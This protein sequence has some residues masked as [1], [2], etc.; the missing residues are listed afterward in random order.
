LLD[1][2]EKEEKIR[3]KRRGKGGSKMEGREEQTV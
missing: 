2:K 3:P 1:Y